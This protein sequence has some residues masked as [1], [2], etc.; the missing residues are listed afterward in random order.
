MSSNRNYW[1]DLAKSEALKT[2]RRA[3]QYTNELMT[4]YQEAAGQIEREIA[5]IYGRYAKDNQL[6]DAVARQYIGGRSIARGACPSTGT[7]RPSPA[8]PRTAGC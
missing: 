1:V 7:S 4:I 6:T 8:P 3:D 5:A 2:E